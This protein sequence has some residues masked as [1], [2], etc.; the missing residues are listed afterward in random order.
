MGRRAYAA[1]RVSVADLSFAL[2]GGVTCLKD[3]IQNS[4]S[5]EDIR[6]KP[7]GFHGASPASP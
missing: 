2:L 7:I 4:L 6:V 3:P 5:G 1:Y